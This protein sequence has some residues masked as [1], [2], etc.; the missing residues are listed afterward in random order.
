MVGVNREPSSVL[1]GPAAE[2]ELGAFRRALEGTLGAAG[3]KTG[4]VLAGIRRE[5][6]GRGRGQAKGLHW[7][8]ADTVAA[9]A[10]NGG[11]GSVAGLRDAALVALASDCLLRVSEAVAV[12]VADL[13]DEPD[14]GGGE[15]PP[16]P[17]NTHAA[18]LPHG[19]PSPASA[20]ARARDDHLPAP[21]SRE[22]RSREPRSAARPRPAAPLDGLDHGRLDHGG[23]PRF[24]GRALDGLDHAEGQAS[25]STGRTARP[26]CTARQ[27]V[28]ARSRRHAA[29]REGGESPGGDRAPPL[30]G[31]GIDS[32]PISRPSEGQ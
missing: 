15:A 13:A 8:A 17:R 3:E 18:R 9:V 19:A 22:P 31:V 14:G 24:D 23:R 2:T 1:P 25:A 7:S 30:S 10:A 27:G 29:A 4:R 20:T 11:R 32:G 16:C 28:R 12:Q 5:G 26:A 21:R 6:R